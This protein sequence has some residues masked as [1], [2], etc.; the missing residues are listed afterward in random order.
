MEAEHDMPYITSIER[1][2]EARGEARGI[3]QGIER[4]RIELLKRQLEHRFGP[5]PTWALDQLGK[6][7]TTQVDAWTFRVLDSKKLEDVFC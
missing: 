1:R 2:A 6:A 7:P 5:L 3:T 4:G